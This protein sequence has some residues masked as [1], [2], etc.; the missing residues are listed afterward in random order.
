MR[1]ILVSVAV[2]VMLTTTSFGD[3]NRINI[4]PSQVPDETEPRVNYGDAPTGYGPDSWQGPATGKTNWHARYLADGDYLSA[5][6]P[7]DAATMTVADLAEISYYTNR[8]TGTPA[9][10]DWW[11]MIYTRPNGVADGSSWYGYRFINNYQDH[12]STGAWAQYSTGDADWT[13]RENRINGPEQSF[14]DFKSTYGSELV[15]MISVHTDSGWDGFDGY[16][17]G[18]EI[19]LT[20]DNVGQV[21]FV[22][23]PGAVLLGMLGLSVAGARLRKKRA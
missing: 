5:L 20:N 9:G 13:L 2:V 22:P 19:R 8:P 16:M 10:R 23:V 14:A 1:K 6:F 11:I 17:D 15:E 4:G 21:N 12:T 18:L 7:D 3:L